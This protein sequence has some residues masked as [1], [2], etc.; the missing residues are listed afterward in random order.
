MLQKI[1]AIPSR[2]SASTRYLPAPRQI[3]NAVDAALRQT[4][5]DRLTAPGS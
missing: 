2:Q 5:C 4:L 3:M 1:A